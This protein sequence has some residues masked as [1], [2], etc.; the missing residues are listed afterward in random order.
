MTEIA[1]FVVGI[2]AGF[3][4]AILLSRRDWR[5]LAPCPH[6]HCHHRLPAPGLKRGGVYVGETCS[7]CQGSVRWNNRDDRYDR[8]PADEVGR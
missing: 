7:V 1:L 6:E 5:N 2:A 4:G 3:G 8:I